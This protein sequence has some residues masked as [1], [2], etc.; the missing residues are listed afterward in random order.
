MAEEIKQPAQQFTVQRIYVKDISF[1]TP[2][3]HEVF[4]QSWKPHVNLEINW[5]NLRIDESNF[6]VV[7]TLS[8]TV[9]IEEKTV[10]LAEV[11]QAGIFY[12]SGI[13]D[14]QLHQVLGTVCLSLLFPYAREAIDNMVVRGSFPPLMLAPVNFDALYAQAMQQAQ[15]KAQ[16]EKEKKEAGSAH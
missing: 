5:R 13:P 14:P 1:E 16:A 6:E 9:S 8:V 10:F 2:Q 3:G 15:Q 12:V 7:L 4:R 11:Q